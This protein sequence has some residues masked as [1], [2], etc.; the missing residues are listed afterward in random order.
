MI[1]ELVLFLLSYWTWVTSSYWLRSLAKDQAVSGDVGRELCKGSVL[2]SPLFTHYT[3]SP[4]ALIQP[5]VRALLNAY[6][7]PQALAW[8]L[9]K[10][11]YP[12]T[13]YWRKSSREQD[14]WL[15]WELDSAI[16]GSS[17]LPLS[18]ESVFHPLFPYMV[19]F[20]RRN[21]Q[22]VMCCWDHLDWVCDWNQLRLLHKLLR[23]WWVSAEIYCVLAA[24]DKPHM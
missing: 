11:V 2:A 17:H 16:G 5:Q 13:H 14:Q 8:A 21:L 3:P 10:L 7:W 1:L 23:F 6:L 15:T 24:Q 18:L 9:S 12:T 4:G 20:Q 19:Q 22:R